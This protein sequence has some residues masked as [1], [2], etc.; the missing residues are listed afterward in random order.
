[1]AIDAARSILS[2][3]YF[4]EQNCKTGIEGLENY[5]K[6]W[7]EAIGNWSNDP[8]HD[9]HS[10]PAD[11]FMQFAQGWDPS[12]EQGAIKPPPRTAAHVPFSPGMGL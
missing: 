10:H 12:H 8:V 2:E 4:H 5:R 6:K 1:M 3:C 11:A 7:N 9:E